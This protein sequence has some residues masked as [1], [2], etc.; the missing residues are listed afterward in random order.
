MVL[1]GQHHIVNIAGILLGKQRVQRLSGILH[2]VQ[3]AMG[4][5]NVIPAYGEVQKLVI[6]RFRE[7]DIA[8]IMKPLLKPPGDQPLH[9]IRMNTVVFILNGSQMISVGRVNYCL[10]NLIGQ[11][12]DRLCHNF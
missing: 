1:I 2:V 9:V 6:L 11:N 3:V 12:T 10:L 4:G 7:N 5:T 8:A